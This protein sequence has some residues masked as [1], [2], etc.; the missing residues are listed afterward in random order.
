MSETFI[1]NL[2][3]IKYG[4]KLFFFVSCET[5]G[6]SSNEIAIGHDPAKVSSILN[7]CIFS[8]YKDFYYF[9]EDWLVLQETFSGV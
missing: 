2:L 7:P 1:K 4:I 8:E 9:M 6:K 3:L 5:G